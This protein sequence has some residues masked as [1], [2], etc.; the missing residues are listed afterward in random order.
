MSL[1]LHVTD[2]LLQLME[3]MPRQSSPIALF[4]RLFSC[5]RTTISM[6]FSRLWSRN[7]RFSSFPAPRPHGLL[8]VLLPHEAAPLREDEPYGTFTALRTIRLCRRF[9][10]ADAVRSLPLALACAN[11][12]EILFASSSSMASAS[13]DANADGGKRRRLGEACLVVVVGAC[14]AF[15]CCCVVSWAEEDSPT[16][17]SGKSGNPGT[18]PPLALLLLGVIVVDASPGPCDSDVAVY[19]PRWSFFGSAKL[20]HGAST[21]AGPMVRLAVAARE[22][23]SSTTDDEEEDEVAAPSA[24]AGDVGG[25]AGD[26][27]SGRSWWGT[28]TCAAAVV[29]PPSMSIV[30]CRF[31]CV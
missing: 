6:R 5:S 7:R 17:K 2:Y 15:V 16:Q 8:W 20:Y 25:G 4:R 29:Q 1:L 19:R 30:C 31:A 14:F 22:S 13:E 26:G 28:G 11:S 9:D 23:S 12:A 27:F 21:V 10:D 18:P 24:A 3:A